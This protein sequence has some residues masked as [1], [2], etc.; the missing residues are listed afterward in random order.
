[1]Q[2]NGDSG[3]GTVFMGAL[4]WVAEDLANVFR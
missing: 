3:N 4:W 2:G 1:M